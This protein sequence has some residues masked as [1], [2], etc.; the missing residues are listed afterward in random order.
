MLLS[1]EQAGLTGVKGSIVRKVA[2]GRSVSN[3]QDALET[4]KNT[5][6]SEGGGY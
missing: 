6:E 4:I 3:L 2:V 1:S 5:L